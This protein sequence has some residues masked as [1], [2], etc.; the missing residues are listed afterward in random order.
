MRQ[1]SLTISSASDAPEMSPPAKK[2]IMTSTPL[3]DPT[4]RKRT[5]PVKQGLWH[6]RTAESSPTTTTISMGQP[7]TTTAATIYKGLLLRASPLL[8]NSAYPLNRSNSKTV[9]VGLHAES[10][11]ST[12][13]I[14]G[15]RA[16]IDLDADEAHQLLLILEDLSTG[17][18]RYTG[19]LKKMSLLQQWVGSDV[20]IHSR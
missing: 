12:L 4:V 18:N 20:G 6:P 2:K 13:R 17:W 3:N 1:P 14:C 10:W 7:L 9:V 11:Q 15:V 19:C 8:L 5:H 16:H